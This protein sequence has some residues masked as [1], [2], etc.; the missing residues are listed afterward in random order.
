MKEIQDKVVRQKIETQK[1]HYT[2][3][4]D[5]SDAHARNM[6]FK[7]QDADKLKSKREEHARTTARVI[8]FEVGRSTSAIRN[9]LESYMHCTARV[10]E[11]ADKAQLGQGSRQRSYS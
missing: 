8:K 2:R 3:D 6:E 9:V 11:A 10:K 4:C 5:M 1:Y 7:F